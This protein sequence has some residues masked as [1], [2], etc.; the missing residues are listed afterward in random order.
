M[1]Y[2]K[3]VH[4]QE[5]LK[6]A[7]RKLA[8]QYHPDLNPDTDTTAIMKEINAE[9]EYLFARVGNTFRNSKG[10]TYTKTTTETAED[11]INIINMIIRFKGI[12]IELIGSWLWVTGDTKPYKDT[13]KELGFKWASKK[14]AWCWHQDEW[15]RRR[16]NKSLAEIRMTY[17]SQVFKAREN[18]VATA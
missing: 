3:D 11:F 9:Y 7:Y 2:F 13:L 8:K 5:E 1:K 17:G 18:E 10:E 16:S 4:T 15:K 14:S 12:E 6:A